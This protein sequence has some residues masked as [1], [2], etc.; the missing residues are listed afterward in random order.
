M[1]ET[2]RADFWFSIAITVLG[3]GVVAESLRMPR[4]ENLGVHPMSAPGLTPGLI[5]AVLAGLGIALFLRSLR[6]RALA[7]PAAAPARSEAG[8]GRRLLIALALCLFYATIL[9][10]RVPFWLATALFV[11]T[12]VL[13]FTWQQRKA[14]R[15]VVMAASLAIAVS[16]A[17]TL[18][19]EQV[20]LVR[21]P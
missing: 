8:G 4:L 21:L 14:A 11:F 18:L 13:T 1:S 9:L 19:F 5:G 2:P 15:L 7:A 12:F 16:A 17:V 6:A 10:G 20:F 3:L